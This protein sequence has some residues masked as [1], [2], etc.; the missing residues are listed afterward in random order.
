MTLDSTEDRLQKRV[1]ELE[2]AL[3]KIHSLLSKSSSILINF[4]IQNNLPYKSVRL[5]TANGTACGFGEVMVN[6][7]RNV[8]DQDDMFTPKNHAVTYRASLDL[9]VILIKKDNI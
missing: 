8:G 5:Y 7:S 9:S 1:D 2:T 6:D 3:K 4:D